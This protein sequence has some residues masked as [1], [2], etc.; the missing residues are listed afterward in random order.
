MKSHISH[1]S[2][3]DAKNCIF[4]CREQE[5]P[6]SKKYSDWTREN[7]FLSLIQAFCLRFQSNQIKVSS[8]CY[9]ELHMGWK[10]WRDIWREWIL[11]KVMVSL[12]R[13]W[14]RDISTIDPHNLKIEEGREKSAMLDIWKV[15]LV[16]SWYLLPNNE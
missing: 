12:A 2:G 13:D 16:L 8:E 3:K 15:F 14:V 7:L 9:T 11:L 4:N 10:N 5:R 1:I 6:L